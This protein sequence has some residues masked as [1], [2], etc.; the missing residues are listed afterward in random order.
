MNVSRFVKI[1]A[2]S[3][4]F[5]L[6]TCYSGD[7]SKHPQPLKSKEDIAHASARTD[8]ISIGQLPIEDYPALARFSNLKLG[9]R[10]PE[11]VL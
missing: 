11:R 4:I 2:L 5:D 7:F 9:L 10:S 1:I 6:V 8:A 3:A